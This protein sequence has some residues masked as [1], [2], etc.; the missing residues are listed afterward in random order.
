MTVFWDHRGTA[1]SSSCQLQ[2]YCYRI[3]CRVL[4]Q[5]SIQTAEVNLDRL[6]YEKKLT[7]GQWQT[8]RASSAGCRYFGLLTWSP[9]TESL[10]DI[11]IPVG[12]KT[13]KN[14]ISWLW[15]WK[16]YYRNWNLLWDCI[17]SSIFSS[18]HNNETHE[19]GMGK[20]YEVY[21]DNDAH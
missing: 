20:A 21:I 13:C 14:P 8:R 18:F 11:A 3:S 5:L 4:G 6:L 19:I 17:V 10:R 7:F 12:P 1:T 16:Y 9:K 2:W 15:H